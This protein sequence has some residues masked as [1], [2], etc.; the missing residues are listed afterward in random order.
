[1]GTD[2][3]LAVVSCPE[4]SLR[5]PS[6]HTYSHTQRIRK[7]MCVIPT[8]FAPRRWRL[9]VAGLDPLLPFTDGR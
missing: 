6:I 5:S 3:D 2:A 4:V 7:I 8:F 1:M 9:Q